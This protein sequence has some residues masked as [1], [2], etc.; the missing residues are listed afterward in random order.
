MPYQCGSGVLDHK[1]SIKMN[2][3]GL[4][5]RDIVLGYSDG[6]SDNVPESHMT[7]CI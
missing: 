1:S 2:D 6:F 4:L 7:D 3:F 5:D